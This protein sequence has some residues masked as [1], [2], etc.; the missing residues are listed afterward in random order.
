MRAPV[1]ASVGLL[2]LAA[3]SSPARGDDVNCPPSLGNVT[4]DGNV[5]V[6]APCQLEGTIVIGNVHL[7]A[8]GSLVS[9]AGTRISSRS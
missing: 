5:L 6:A 7:Y 4:I 1:I 2:A 9:R 3:A 8:G